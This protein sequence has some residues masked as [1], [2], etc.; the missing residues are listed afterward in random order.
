MKKLSVQKR[1]RAV[2]TGAN[3]RRKLVA[4]KRQEEAYEK[5]FF[6]QRKKGRF[7][8]TMFSP[9]AY[10]MIIR[11]ES[12][13]VNIDRLFRPLRLHELRTYPKHPPRTLTK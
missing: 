13:D 12:H 3:K 9:R 7:E 6:Q 8:Q 4:Q 1:N 11:F 2:S 5:G 10:P